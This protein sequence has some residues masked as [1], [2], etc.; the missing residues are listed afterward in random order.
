MNSTLQNH[1]KTA[2]FL[3]QCIQTQHRTFATAKKFQ[4]STSK[5]LAKMCINKQAIHSSKQKPTN[6]TLPGQKSKPKRIDE[7]VKRRQQLMFSMRDVPLAAGMKRKHVDNLL[8]L[9]LPTHFLR[10]QAGKLETQ[11]ANFHKEGLEVMRQ[12]VPGEDIHNVEKRKK[13]HKNIHEALKTREWLKFDQLVQQL[14]KQQVPFDEITF[15]LVALGYLVSTSHGDDMSLSIIKEMKSC[16]FVHPSFFRLT[17][18]LVLSHFEVKAVCG[19]GLSKKF[20]RYWILTKY[21]FFS[22]FK[23]KL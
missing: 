18:G 4:T 8:K 15:N 22:D 14:A 10:E 5:A 11:K 12:W 16:R 6:I 2:T 13:I 21:L 20:L 7:R 1:I 23:Y 17:E 19:Q 9:H 3:K